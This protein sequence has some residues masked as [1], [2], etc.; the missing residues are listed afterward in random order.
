MSRRA[1][2]ALLLVAGIAPGAA[3]DA[4][5]MQQAAHRTGAGA[6]AALPALHALLTTDQQGGEAA[7]V[8]AVNRFFNTRIVFRTDLE[9][10]GVEDHWASPLEVLDKGAGDCE[11]Y[12]IGK[13]FTLLAAGVPG[14]RLRLVYVRA[15]L[16]AA[17]GSQ[18]PQAHMVLAYHP[19][20]GSEPSILDN[21]RADIVPASRRPDL[22]PVFSFNHEGL[23][24]GSTPAGDPLARLSRWRQV[25]AKARAEGFL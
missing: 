9:V 14:E 12:A 18:R 20:P 16:R 4:D 7:L 3:W 25:L 8:A 15:L 19:Q 24:Q 23:W 10:W 21:L 5:R 6:V 11:D 17:D 2:C 13:F 1:A 22:T